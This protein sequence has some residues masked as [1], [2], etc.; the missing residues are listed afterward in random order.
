MQEIDLTGRVFGRLT[1]LEKIGRRQNQGLWLCLCECGNK[2]GATGQQLRDE[3][4]QSCGCLLASK[5]VEA[6]KTHGMSKT[7]EYAIW[8]GIRTR[9]NNPTT[10]AYK[11]YGGR[12]IF[13]CESW[14]KPDGFVAFMSDMGPRPLGCSVERR[15]NDGPYS[16]DN[17]Y[18]ATRAEQNRNRRNNHYI[19]VNGKSQTIKDWA[20]ELGCTPASIYRRLK[21]GWP[22]ER[23][24]TQP[25]PKATGEGNSKPEVVLRPYVNGTKLTQGDAEKIRSLYP[26]HSY[27]DLAR[28]YSVDRKTIAN[29][30]K[31]LSFNDD[32]SYKPVE[33]DWKSA[34]RAKIKR[35]SRLITANGQTKTLSE[36]AKELGVAPNTMQGR[37]KSGWTEQDVVTNVERR[38]LWN[39]KLTKEDAAKIRSMYPATSSIKLAEMYSV[40]K[41]TI[42][43]VLHNKTFAQ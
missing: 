13:V 2:T 23:A 39:Q 30:L 5:R 12:G 29:I 41:K 7:A 25:M 31:G 17:C 18:W 8:R 22:A 35:T 1:V 38:P 14:D 16:P 4:T 43:N 3:K 40:S 24:V 27:A 42:L 21:L 26:D 11:D 10:R 15:D 9:C 19:E 37:M 28:M 33:H 32:G 20:N 34:G 6:H 36:W